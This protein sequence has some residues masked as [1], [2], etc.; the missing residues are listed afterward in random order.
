MS[1]ND[2]EIKP[3]KLPAEPKLLVPDAQ[4]PPKE[5]ILK[6]YMQPGGA[7]S[8]YTD[9]AAEVMRQLDV[10]ESYRDA[11]LKKVEERKRQ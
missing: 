3:P 11:L 4:V 8:T 2:D 5:T 6:S 10:I 1:H 9:P 7:A